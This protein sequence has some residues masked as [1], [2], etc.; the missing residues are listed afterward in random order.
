MF[1]GVTRFRF[2]VAHAMSLPHAILHVLGKQRERTRMD[3]ITDLAAGIGEWLSVPVPLV[4]A[5]IM[6]VLVGWLCWRTSTPMIAAPTSGTGTESHSP[7]PAARS[8]I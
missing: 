1:I 6:G 5:A 8:V 4:G 2:D 7:M 3:Q